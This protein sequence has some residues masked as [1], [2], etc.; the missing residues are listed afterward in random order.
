M[1]RSLRVLALLAG[2]VGPLTAQTPTTLRVGTLIDGQG[3]L[4]RN[5]VV[6]VQDGRIQRIEPGRTGPV[7]Y[8]LSH[9]TLLPGLIDTHVHIGGRFGKDGTTAR[10]EGETAGDRLL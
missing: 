7:T 10:R 5:A 2:L 9:L 3:G 4:Q 8:D 6:T 1:I